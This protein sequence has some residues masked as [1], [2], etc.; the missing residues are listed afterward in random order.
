MRETDD[1]SVV[2]RDVACDEGMTRLAAAV[3][4]RAP[5]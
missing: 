2:V 1:R 4:A 5:L 3:E